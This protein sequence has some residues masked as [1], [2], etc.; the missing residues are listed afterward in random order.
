MKR[1]DE[2]RDK[3]CLDLYEGENSRNFMLHLVRA[4]SKL[5]KVKK[6]FAFREKQRKRCTV[7][8]ARLL[9]VEDAI[10][11][12]AENSKAMSEDVVAAVKAQVDGVLPKEHPL[13]KYYKGQTLAYEG[14][15]TDTCVCVECA[16]AINRF[17]MQRLLAEDKG[18]TRVVRDMREK[19]QG[20]VRQPKYAHQ[21][22]PAGQPLS[23]A[24][25]FS[26]MLKKFGRQARIS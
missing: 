23:E 11:V 5:E 7:C 21:N 19:E 4:Y 26:E 24:P 15:A 8:D 10:K 3:L 22:V 12:V 13:S 25:G 16:V 14:D 20:I 9:S 18:I 2:E 17:T 6:V 1:T